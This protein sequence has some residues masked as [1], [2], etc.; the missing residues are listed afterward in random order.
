M[1]VPD[2]QYKILQLDRCMLQQAEQAIEESYKMARS[3]LDR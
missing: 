3:V 1:P 2:H